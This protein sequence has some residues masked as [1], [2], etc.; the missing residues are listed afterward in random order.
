MSFLIKF[1]RETDRLT[2]KAQEIATAAEDK[3][4]GWVADGASAQA[5]VAKVP[6]VHSAAC[7]T[8][9]GIVRDHN[10]DA[11]RIVKARQGDRCLVTLA[12]GM[13]G[14]NSGE[15][16]SKMAI[17]SIVAFLDLDSL[18]PDA[19]LARLVEQALNQANES[20]WRHASDNPQHQ[21]MGTTVCLLLMIGSNCCVGWVGDSRVY[22]MR[23]GELHQLTKDD[24][25]VNKL[26]A[27]GI[28]TEQ[29]AAGHP[30][31]HVLSQALGT[32]GSLENAH[33]LLINFLEPGDR[34]LLTTDGVH[35]VLEF[36]GMAQLMRHEDPA[37][38]CTR[39]VQAG[40]DA[41]STDNLSAAVV[42]VRAQAD[43]VKSAAIT[44]H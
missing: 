40:K 22:Y 27:D 20:V 14:H 19:N 26:V 34:F 5:L 30:D 3:L 31:A 36:Q 43:T 8:D 37:D 35:D 15:V 10:E 42:A 2:L 11:V 21:G 33:T 29:Q 38:V 12:D 25:L 23:K 17:D 4:R 6:L 39:L 1:K 18:Q 44:R 7:L 16:A 41:K 9:T 13:G 24:T 28:L 32:H